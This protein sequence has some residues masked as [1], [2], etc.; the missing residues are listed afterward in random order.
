MKD[1]IKLRIASIGAG[2]AAISNVF[3]ILFIILVLLEKFDFVSE[4]SWIILF[5]MIFINLLILVGYLVIARIN[6]LTGFRNLVI[7]FFLLLIVSSLRGPLLVLIKNKLIVVIFIIILI[8]RGVLSILIGLEMKKMVK[9]Y[10]KVMKSLSTVEIIL[11]IMQVTVILYI[12]TP[13]VLI[14]E[15]V[16]ESRLFFNASNKIKGR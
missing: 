1:K 8:I 15:S 9:K 7:S 2:I 11:G 16:L 10:G 4:S 14:Y 12:F 3:S 13:F 5:I 6:K